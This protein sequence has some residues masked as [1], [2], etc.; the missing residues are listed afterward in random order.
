M[1]AKLSFLVYF[2]TKLFEWNT[3]NTLLNSSSWTV[4]EKKLHL[5][6]TKGVDCTVLLSAL[7]KVCY[8]SL[9][10]LPSRSSC[11]VDPQW[12]SPASIPFTHLATPLTL[13]S[14]MVNLELSRWRLCMGRTWSCP[15]TAVTTSSNRV[16]QV[17]WWFWKRI[18]LSLQRL[19]NFF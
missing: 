14:S 3:Y 6:H 1:W 18:C 16:S 19:K 7:H 12:P 5:S 17:R 4:N 8:N 11:V 10:C 9:S 13:C 2:W 15:P